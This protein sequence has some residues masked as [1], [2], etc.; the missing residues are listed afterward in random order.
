VAKHDVPYFSQWESPEIVPDLLSGGRRASD[1]PKWTA[2][3]ALTPEEYEFWSSKIC[4]MACLRMI[5]A[6]QGHEVPP[7]VSLAK[8]CEEHGGYVRQKAGVDGLI[9]APFV[10]W[11]RAKFGIKCEVRGTLSFQDLETAVRGG[12]LVMASVHHTIRWPDRHPP[13]R[14]GHLVL[15]TEVDDG[16]VF[17]NNPSGLPAVNQHRAQLSW[18]SLEPFYAYRGILFPG[19]TKT[20][21]EARI[22]LERALLG[23]IDDVEIGDYATEEVVE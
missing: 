14:G 23:G 10:A 19:M 15:V 1:D 2:S 12:A 16:H 11:V 18:E 13:A 21:R 8:E 9:Y 6:Y 4:G 20:I 3:G 5:L 7:A 22:T 17:F